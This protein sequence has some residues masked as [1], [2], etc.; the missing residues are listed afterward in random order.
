L[1]KKAAAP[2]D[3]ERLDTLSRLCRHSHL[4]K[5]VCSDYFFDYLLITR[6]KKTPENQGF[7]EQMTGNAFPV[8]CGFGKAFRSVFVTS[9]YDFFVRFAVLLIF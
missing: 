9:F 5:N 1:K 2:Q 6:N 4:I 3:I 7:C 8:F